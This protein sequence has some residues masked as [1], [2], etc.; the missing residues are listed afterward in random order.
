[1]GSDALARGDCSAGR[2]GD[3]DPAPSDRA[4]YNAATRA[5]AVDEYNWFYAAAPAGSGSCGTTAPPCIAPLTSDADFDNYIVPTDAAFDLGFILSNDPRPFYAHVTNL[6][7]DRWRTPARQHPGPVPHRLHARH[8]LVNLTL[9][10]AVDQL[11]NQQQWATDN[12]TVTGYVL[13]GAVTIT[14]SRAT[15]YHS[16]LP[17]VDD[18]RGDAR[19]LRGRSLRLAHRRFEDGHGTRQHAGRHRPG[20]PI[21]RGPHHD[22]RRFGHADCDRVVH[23]R[24]SRRARGHHQPGHSH[25]HDHRDRGGR[26][27]G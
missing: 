7:G 12:N 24:T 25:D 19:T 15:P 23:R 2:G 4:Y 3:H 10:Q 8:T 13:N 18:R 22:H 20:V 5:Q 27:C 21:G 14:N 26:Q 16:P 11:M 17:R 1:M 6:V 9:T